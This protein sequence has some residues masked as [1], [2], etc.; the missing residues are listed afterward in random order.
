MQ[1]RKGW[2]AYI[3]PSYVLAP[4]Y[5][6]VCVYVCVCKAQSRPAHSLGKSMLDVTDY[7]VA[8]CAAV[9]VVAVAVTAAVT[10]TALLLLMRNNVC[11]FGNRSKVFA[12]GKGFERE[13][14]LRGKY[15]QIVELSKKIFYKCK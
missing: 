1:A 5:L 6:C 2:R 9:T 14:K 8:V 3:Q 10:V 11:H 12:K 13:V 4:K 7:C 15:V